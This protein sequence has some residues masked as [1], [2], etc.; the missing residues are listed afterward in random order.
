[1]P[2]E[3]PV[4]QTT[5]PDNFAVAFETSKDCVAANF[6]NQPYLREKQWED[7]YFII[8]FYPLHGRITDTY[9]TKTGTYG[10]IS[11]H[12]FS[13]MFKIS[14]IYGYNRQKIRQIGEQPLR[15]QPNSCKNYFIKCCCGT[16][17]N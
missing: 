15:L 13:K 8:L 17:I 1:M 10:L 5:L 9:R 4:I 6:G 12:H 3:A 14:V 16:P 11:N 7:L 2:D